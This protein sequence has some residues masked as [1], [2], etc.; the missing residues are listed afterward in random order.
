MCFIWIVWICI[1]CDVVCECGGCGF[2]YCGW[3]VGMLV[4][5]DVD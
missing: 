3:V 1:N 5:C 4:I 2:V